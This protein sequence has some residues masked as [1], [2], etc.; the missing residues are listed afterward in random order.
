MNANIPD[1]S[2]HARW[3]LQLTVGDH[4]VR[5]NFYDPAARRIHLYLEKSWR[6][7]PADALRKIEDAVY[8]DPVVVDDYTTC[9]LVRP[10]AMVFVPRDSL[11]EDAEAHA[12]ELLSLLDA[13][14][15]KDVWIEPATQELTALFTTPGG[16][17]DFLAR[18]FPTEDVHAALLPMLS[19]VIASFEP[20]GEKVWV[21]IDADTLDI[22]ALRNGA[23]SLINTREYEDAADAA[24]YIVYALRAIEFA[25]GCEVRVSGN[26]T[27]RRE[28][29]PMLRRHLEFVSNALLPTHIRQALAAGISLCET[30]KMIK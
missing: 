4:G 3:R 14:E 27:V 11:P 29:L 12:E 22:V 23:P 21:H 16:T 13:T 9:I 15:N 24:Y 18:T 6:C 19:H 8:D 7:D 1:I 2:D 5:A 17:R 30:I 10:G 25:P 26:E 28:L 20:H